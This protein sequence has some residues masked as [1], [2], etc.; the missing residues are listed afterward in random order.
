MIKYVCIRININNR[1]TDAYNTNWQISLICEH[2]DDFNAYRNMQL[3][4]TKRQQTNQ[5]NVVEEFRM[6]VLGI[7]LRTNELR[8]T[9][10]SMMVMIIIITSRM[11]ASIQSMTRDYWWF[12]SWERKRLF[13][14]KIRNQC[15][16]MYVDRIDY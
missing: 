12:S 9:Y 11:F 16:R 3:N 5:P 2:F 15:I 8:M 10:E 4:R 14:R 1:S 13:K 6:N 7:K